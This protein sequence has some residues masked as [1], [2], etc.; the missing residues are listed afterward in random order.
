MIYTSQ[1]QRQCLGCE[2]RTSS[3]SSIRFNIGQSG[4]KGHLTDAV[5]FQKSCDC[6]WAL[7]V[8]IFE[9]AA[10][11]PPF[12][13]E[14]RVTMFRNICQV[15]Y[16]CP[17]HFSKVMLCESTQLCSLLDGLKAAV[18]QA[19]PAACTLSCRLMHCIQ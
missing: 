9:M 19:V 3:S 14:D 4:F 8:L 2:A 15:K 17:P 10:G 18:V 16:T 11:H 6:R 13:H 7:G 12:Y 1:F 5:R